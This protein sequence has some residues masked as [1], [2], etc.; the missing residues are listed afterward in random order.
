[1]IS[2]M[3]TDKDIRFMQVALE[4]ARSALSKGEF[5]VGCVI[6]D[7]ARVV[8]R[9]H[10]TGTSGGPGNEIDHAEI[11]ALRV[12][13]DIEPAVDR[14]TLSIYCTMEPCLMCFSAIL[15]SGISRII[16]AYEDIM[17]GGTQSDRSGL[18][19]LY[20]DTQVTVLSGVLRQ[21]SLELFRQ[22]FSTS[23][24]TYWAD[25]ELCRYTLEQMQSR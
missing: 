24:N 25:S 1:M 11:N 13:N 10:R 19:P 12:L 3:V 14:S 22:F 21:P 9:G 5:P 18:A 2:I 8:S 6:A 16:F 17:G 20:R 4:M 23:G 15:L 7:N